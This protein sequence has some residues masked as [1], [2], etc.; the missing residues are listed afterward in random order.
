MQSLA[1]YRRLLARDPA[2]EIELTRAASAV[3]IA[4]YGANANHLRPADMWRATVWRLRRTYGE[5]LTAAQVL[6]EMDEP[7]EKNHV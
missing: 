1:Y 3:Y 6:S 5:T 7:N 4:R 2:A